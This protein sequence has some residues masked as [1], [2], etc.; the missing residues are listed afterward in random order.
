MSIPKF[1][2]KTNTKTLNL[3]GETIGQTKRQER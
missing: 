3:G 1:A 2:V